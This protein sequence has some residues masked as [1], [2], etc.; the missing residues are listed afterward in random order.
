MTHIASI[1]VFGAVVAWSKSA[2]AGE[3]LSVGRPLKTAHSVFEIR[4]ASSFAAVHREH[5][6]LRTRVAGRAFVRRSSRRAVCGGTR[7]NECEPLTVGAPAR[8]VRI[9][10]ARGE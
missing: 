5:P 9:L 3:P 4:D 6:N 2:Y 1:F 7:R 8:R 10:W